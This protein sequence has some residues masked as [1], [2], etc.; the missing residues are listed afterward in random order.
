MSTERISWTSG[1]PTTEFILYC[2]RIGQSV[3]GNYTTIRLIIKAYNRG[4]TSSWTGGGG[5]HHGWVSGDAYNTQDVLHQTSSN[6][7]P[8]GYSTGELRWSVTRDINIKHGSDGTRGSVTLNQH[9]NFDGQ[10]SNKDYTFNDFPDIDVT[11]VPDAPTANA[12][13]S[14]SDNSAVFN[15]DGND[16]GGLS[17]TNAEVR[18]GT[19][20][21]AVG[22]KTATYFTTGLAYTATGLS[23]Y[24]TYYYWGRVYN[25]KGWSA[26][27]NR[28]T[29]KTLADLP[30]APTPIALDSATQT[31]A[32][33]RFSG[34]D[35]GGAPI[36][37]WQVGYGTDPNNVQTTIAANGDTTLTG[38]TRNTTYYV[39][40]RGHN[41]QG[42]GPWSARSQITT[43]AYTPGPPTLTTLDTVTMNSV[44]L[45]SADNVDN[46]GSGVDSRQIGYG[47]DPNNVQATVNTDGNDIVGGLSPGTTYYFWSRTHN[48]AG[49]SDWSNRMSAH[50]YAGSRVRVVGVWREAIPWVRVAGVWKIAQPYVRVAG[51][52]KRTG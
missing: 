49:W 22:A 23:R 7:L 42:W 31:T 38:L 32:R 48:Q 26:W 40:S 2:D 33:Y 41:V 4:S 24:T 43:L 9:V 5:Y 14:I 17:I 47:T 18:W 27:S 39:W 13:S 16:N 19:D 12:A 30:A 3:S 10:D 29:F 28:I 45:V 52:W 35:D 51:V 6:F 50:T 46:G 15:I 21:N 11:T 20:P 25:S 36:D 8:S 37:Q 1:T 44:H 34:N